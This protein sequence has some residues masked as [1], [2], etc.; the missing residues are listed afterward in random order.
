MHVKKRSGPHCPSSQFQAIKIHLHQDREIDP[1][2][3]RTDRSHKDTKTN[4]EL[5]FKP[6]TRNKNP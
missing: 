2:Q 5:N 4:P 3:D 6:K 1:R